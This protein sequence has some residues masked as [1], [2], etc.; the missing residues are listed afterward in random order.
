MQRLKLFRTLSALVLPLLIQACITSASPGVPLGG[1]LPPPMD[2]PFDA[3]DVCIR[4][5]PPVAVW[6]QGRLEDEQRGCFRQTVQVNHL[7]LPAGTTADQA[8]AKYEACL[9]QNG[10]VSIGIGMLDFNGNKVNSV[11]EDCFRSAVQ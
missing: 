2:P 11:R 10:S 7:T 1:G 4:N 6:Q 8:F 5:L 9:K 3:Y